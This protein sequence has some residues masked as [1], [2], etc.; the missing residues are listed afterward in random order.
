MSILN[1]EVMMRYL[2]KEMTPEESKEF[3]SQVGENPEIQEE[4]TEMKEGFEKLDDI[5][6]S[7]STSVI[8]RIMQYGSA[9]EEAHS[10]K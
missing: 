4:F 7:P 6:Y 5:Q 8:D 2:Y 10:K 1:S 9:V 3:L